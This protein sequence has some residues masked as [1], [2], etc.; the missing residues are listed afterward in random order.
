MSLA[1]NEFLYETRK[2]FAES[3]DTVTAS[4]PTS[5][6]YVLAITTNKEESSNILI[7]FI[8]YYLTVSFISAQ[9]NQ[10][11]WNEMINTYNYL[12]NIT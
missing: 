7:D 9:P 3:G 1:P 10:F 4:P 6:T 12:Y 5:L 8:L 2:R 11:L